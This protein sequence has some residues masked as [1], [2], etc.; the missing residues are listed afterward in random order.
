MKDNVKDPG[1]L[2]KG[3][4]SL[5]VSMASQG[6][7]SGDI[8]S[9]SAQFQGKRVLWVD[10]YPENNDHFRT[11]LEQQGVSFTLALTTEQGMKNLTSAKYDLVI[12]DMGRGPD[13]QA[14]IHL[15]QQMREAKMHVPT[16]IFASRGAIAMYGEETKRLGAQYA[17]A[18]GNILLQGMVE[19]LA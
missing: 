4:E 18:S 3:C 10:D 6:M 9:S 8:S 7:P 15:L 11:L 5:R 17:T 12:S 14:G 19:L 1:S 13:G 16:I 2:S